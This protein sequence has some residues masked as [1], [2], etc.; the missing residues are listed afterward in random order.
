[1]HFFTVKSNSFLP[2]QLCT[3]SMHRWNSGKWLIIFFHL[4]RAG[5]HCRS[6]LKSMLTVKCSLSFSPTLLTTVSS[7]WFVYF[8]FRWQGISERPK[9]G[10]HW[11]HLEVVT[12]FASYKHM[13]P[14]RFH[15]RRQ[16]GDREHIFCIILWCK[17]CAPCI[18]RVSSSSSLSRHRPKRFSTSQ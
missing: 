2:F 18:C 6:A 4:F 5:R 11:E 10:E 17:N 9:D 3:Y 15:A 1:M 16:E 14:V 8:P 12:H 13:T 7:R